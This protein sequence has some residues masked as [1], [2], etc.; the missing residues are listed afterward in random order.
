MA[1]IGGRF[2]RQQYPD[3][4]RALSHC[5]LLGFDRVSAAIIS[6]FMLRE[7]FQAYVS[8]PLQNTRFR[9]LLTQSGHH[10]ISISNH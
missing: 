6:G 10:E 9:F 4:R 2:P 7:S 3:H 8:L 1:V 5:A